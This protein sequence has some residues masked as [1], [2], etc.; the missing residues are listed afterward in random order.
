MMGS[1]LWGMTPQRRQLETQ[2]IRQ[3]GNPRLLLLTL[4]YYV[5][6]IRRKA[7][8]VLT[9]DAFFNGNVCDANVLFTWGKLDVRHLERRIKNAQVGM[10]RNSLH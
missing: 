4:N 8:H 2:P 10:S 6:T 3:R 9:V 1:N 7:L 5:L